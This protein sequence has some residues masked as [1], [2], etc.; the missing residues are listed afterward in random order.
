MLHLG[1]F[2]AVDLTAC[3]L[4]FLACLPCN[5]RAAVG[6]GERERGG[7]EG[8]VHFLRMGFFSHYYNWVTT[9]MLRP[10]VYYSL[11]EQDMTL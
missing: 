5:G 10:K 11:C 7:G 9:L 6:L 8:A 3:G 1:R 2:L 4:L